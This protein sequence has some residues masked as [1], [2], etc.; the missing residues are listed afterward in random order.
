MK[1]RKDIL[2]L[3]QYFYPEY[4]T[5]AQLPFDTVMALKKAGFSVDVLCG[6]PREYLEGSDVPS[7]EVVE[8][9]SIRRLKYLQLN[10]AGFLGRLVNYFSFTM[11]VL[12]HL[13]KLAKYKSVLVYSNPPILPWVASWG[14][15][16]FGTKLVFVAYDLYP[17]AATVTG[18][19]RD[20]SLICSLMRHINR[21][22]FK[23]ASGVVALSSE[24]KEYIVRNRSYPPE[25]IFVIPNWFAQTGEEMAPREPNP[26]RERSGGRF[27]VSYFGNMGTMQDMQTIMDAMRELKKDDGLFFRFAGHGNK[28]Q[29]LKDFL[30]REGM[31]NAEVLPF[32]HGQDFQDALDAS[33]CALVSL[34]PGTVGLCVPSKTYCYMFH[35][36]PLAAVMEPCDIVRD[37]ESGAGIWVKN[38]QPEELARELRMLSRDSDRCKKMGGVCRELYR[39]CYAK[40]SGTE[41]YVTLF[42]ELLAPGQEKGNRI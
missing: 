27:T 32:L 8:G 40:Q 42:R 10:R 14:K 6:Y 20:G 1:P 37:I 31:T 39:K 26:F 36:I 16:L 19:L 30:L 21:V 18:T 25:K 15:A 5:S 17:E 11:M 2:F 13:G 29:L 12:L 41:K 38:G 7:Q 33:D 23:R 4:I 35:G 22:M 3:C 34:A 24:E 28:Q 9:V